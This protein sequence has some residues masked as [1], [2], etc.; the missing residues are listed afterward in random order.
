MYTL[1]THISVEGILDPPKDPD[2]PENP[3]FMDPDEVGL[4]F[5]KLCSRRLYICRVYCT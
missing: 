3:D 1:E 5:H 4:Y 2:E